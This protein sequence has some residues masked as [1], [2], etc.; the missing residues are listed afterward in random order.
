MLQFQHEMS[1]YFQLTKYSA[2]TWVG[3]WLSLLCSPH[4]IHSLPGFRIITVFVRLPQKSH[5]NCSQLVWHR[6]HVPLQVYFYFLHWDEKQTSLCICPIASHRSGLFTCCCSC[7]L[8]Q[9]ILTSNRCCLILSCLCLVPQTEM[10]VVHFMSSGL[11]PFEVPK[12]LSHFSRSKLVPL[13]GHTLTLHLKYLVQSHVMDQWIFYTT[14]ATNCSQQPHNQSGMQQSS[15]D[16]FDIS[17]KLKYLQRYS[18][19][20]KIPL[21]CLIA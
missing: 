18:N 2:D 17:K 3:F 4:P 9:C 1:I 8:S 20:L 21:K 19:N 10:S 7:C 15:L 11:G 13:N 6:G 16:I 12:H 14:E 5:S